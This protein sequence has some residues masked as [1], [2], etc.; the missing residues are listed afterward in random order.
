MF[1][2]ITTL[3]LVQSTAGTAAS[4][5]GGDG[6][7]LAEVIQALP[8]DPASLVALALVVGFFGAMVWFGTRKPPVKPSAG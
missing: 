8:T 2:P 6:L 3:L 1:A 5:P 7:T 4:A